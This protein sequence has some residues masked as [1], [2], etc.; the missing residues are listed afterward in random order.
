MLQE[1]ARDYRHNQNIADINRLF[2]E[3]KQVSRRI[4]FE[5]DV[6]A[7]QYLLHSLSD[8]VQHV[9][10]IEEKTPLHKRN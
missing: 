2:N 1:S 8:G 4:A 3:L 10:L 5:G 7:N 6:V 9:F